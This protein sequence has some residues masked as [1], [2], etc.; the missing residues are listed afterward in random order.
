MV[1][2]CLYE[3]RACLCGDILFP[4]LSNLQFLLSLCC[5]IKHPFAATLLKPCVFLNNQ[6]AAQPLNKL[7]KIKKRSKKFKR[8]Q[9]NRFARVSVC[10]VALQACDS[11]ICER[12]FC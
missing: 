3:L 6:V 12:F 11:N 5:S 10:C 8:F 2:L 7:K 9:S 4:I 1:G